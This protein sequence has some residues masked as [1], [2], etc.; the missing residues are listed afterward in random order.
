MDERVALRLKRRLRC[1]RSGRL[2]EWRSWI[3]LREERAKRHVPERHDPKFGVRR[4][5]NLEPSLAP[6]AL[7]RRAS[8]LTNDE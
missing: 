5:E 7:A 8:R 6:P 4:F 1:G 3:S 2:L